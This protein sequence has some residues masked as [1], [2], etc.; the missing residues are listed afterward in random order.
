MSKDYPRRSAEGMLDGA[1]MDPLTE[2]NQLHLRRRGVPAKKNL[3]H[4]VNL[5]VG[6]AV[7]K[8]RALFEEI[9][10]PRKHLRMRYMHVSGFDRWTDRGS[11]PG[12]M[13]EI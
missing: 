1:N 12:M 11:A 13:P 4:G 6:D 2:R 9:Y 5:I 3:G 7:G 10:H 8:R